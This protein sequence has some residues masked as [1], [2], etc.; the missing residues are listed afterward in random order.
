MKGEFVYIWSFQVKR[1]S[2]AAFERAYGPAGD[3]VQL[4]RKA[5]GYLKTELL[6]DTE[7]PGRYV[8]IDHWESERA[9]HSF[10]ERF[11]AEFEAI[12]KSCEALT[13]SETL[14]GHFEVFR[15]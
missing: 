9:Q 5:P 8:T 4:F 11:A 1:G 10:R 14:I 13:E 6:S 12:D 7:Q 2:E 15:K 3:W